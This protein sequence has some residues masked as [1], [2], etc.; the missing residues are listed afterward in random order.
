M[1][2]RGWSGDPPATDEEAIDRI[3]D[4]AD[5]IIAERGSALRI[6]DVARSLGVTRQTVYRYFPGAEAL[7]LSTAM[8][9][10]HGF[11]EQLAEHVRGLTD[12][13]SALVEGMAFTV[14]TL[15]QDDR[16]GFLL[17]TRTRGEVSG[18]TTSDVALTFSR[19]ILHRYDVDWEASGFDDA[20][21]DELSE[22]CL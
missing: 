21:L 4:V 2:N 14:E 7:L 11:L 5:A 12:P 15:T 18:S 16:I 17:T 6:A 10:G 22:F 20:A 13:V 3:L 19:S 8:R 9:S 1:A